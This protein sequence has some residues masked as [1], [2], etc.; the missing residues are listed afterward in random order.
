LFFYLESQYC[1]IFVETKQS[2]DDI[3][4]VLAH[5]NVSNVIIHDDRTE[6]QCFEVVQE[7]TNGK[8][9]ILIITSNVARHLE[10]PSVDCIVNYDL[11]DSIDF[12][13]YCISQTGKIIKKNV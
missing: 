9:Q 6:K 1:L 3:G 10:F 11:P 8:Y 7:F 4:A 5:K 2:A 13:S 12:Y